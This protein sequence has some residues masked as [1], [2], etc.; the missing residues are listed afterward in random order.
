[1]T[2]EQV[3]TL[4]SFAEQRDVIQAEVSSLTK[5]RDELLAK[6]KELSSSNSAL[7]S[8]VEIYQEQRKSVVN[9]IHSS[10]KALLEEK[11]K[12]EKDL[13]SIE[14]KIN[15]SRAELAENISNIKLI[16]EQ[17]SGLL[18]FTEEIK[19]SIKDS[20]EEVS[21]HIE[22]V[23]KSSSDC[24]E[25]VRV[26]KNISEVFTLEVS[27]VYEEIAN[28]RSLLDKREI[29]LNDRQRAIDELVE[30]YKKTLLQEHGR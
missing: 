26:I 22:T 6:N 5:Q 24:V 25:S 9:E 18:E 30:D 4:K 14:T 27:S 15:E 7:N 21:K 20:S 23:K 29:Y 3:T 11:I 12:L 19:S 8:E 2:P 17:L 28:K 10:T 1:M 16:K 13:S